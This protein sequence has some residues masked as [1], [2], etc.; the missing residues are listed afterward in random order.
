[1][2]TKPKGRVL[3]SN[4]LNPICYLE[5]QKDFVLVYFPWGKGRFGRMYCASVFKKFIGFLPP[6]DGT[7]IRVRFYA[8]V[9]K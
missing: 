6:K 4:K 5:R 3:K 1:M 7:P 2:K 8:E 9:V